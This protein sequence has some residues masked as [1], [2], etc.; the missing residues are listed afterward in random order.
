MLH[1]SAENRASGKL[2]SVSIFL[3]WGDAHENDAGNASYY[4][5]QVL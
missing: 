3:Y 4:E 1:C 5:K 2:Q